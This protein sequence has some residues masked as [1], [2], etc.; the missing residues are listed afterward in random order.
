[1]LKENPTE[2]AYA[3]VLLH[4]NRILET[5]SVRL[6]ERNETVIQLQDELEAYDRI[7]FETLE[8]LKLKNV[9][10]NGLVRCCKYVWTW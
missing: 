8:L 9:K 4:Q 6:G 1:M 2:E 7:H 10:K 5:L 3:E